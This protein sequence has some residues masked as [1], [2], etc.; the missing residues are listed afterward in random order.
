MWIYHLQIRVWHYLRVGIQIFIFLWN[1][2]DTFYEK[3]N[4]SLICYNVD[5]K[6]E[7]YVCYYLEMAVP[8]ILFKERDHL[9]RV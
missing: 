4:K 9:L 8:G 2:C 5:N 7:V 6:S 1:S 3:S